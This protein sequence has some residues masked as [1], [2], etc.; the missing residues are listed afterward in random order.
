MNTVRQHPILSKRVWSHEAGLT[1]VQWVGLSA[2]ALVA[3]VVIVGVFASGGSQEI[4]QA[5]SAGTD[6]RIDCLYNNCEPWQNN[7]AGPRAGTAAQSSGGASLKTAGDIAAASSSDGAN[8]KAGSPSAWDRFW[9][10]AGDLLGRG[11]QF[12]KRLVSDLGDLAG[13]AIDGIAGWWNGLP[14]WAKGLIL[15]IGVAIVVVVALV[16]LSVAWPVVVLAGIGAVAGGLIY[17]ISIGEQGQFNPLTGI[18]F[19]L[20]GAAAFGILGHVGV[21]AAAKAGTIAGVKAAMTLFFKTA[22]ATTLKSIVSW[23]ITGDTPTLE[24]VWLD[25]TTSVIAAHL[26]TKLLDRVLAVRAGKAPGLL[27]QGRMHGG[28]IP[29]LVDQL[30]SWLNKAKFGRVSGGVGAFKVIGAALKE[31]VKQLLKA[32]GKGHLPEGEDLAKAGLKVVS[33]PLVPDGVVGPIIQAGAVEAIIEGGQRVLQPQPAPSPT[34]QRP[35]LAPAP[36]PTP[37]PGP[38]PIYAPAT[39]PRSPSTT[40]V[41]VQTPRPN[42]TPAPVGTPR[43]NVTPA[44]T[45][46]ANQTLAPLSTSRPTV[47]PAPT[48][49]PK[50]A[51]TPENNASANQTLAPLSTARPAAAPAPTNMPKPAVTPANTTSA[52]QTLAPAGTTQPIVTPES[53]ASST[54]VPINTPRPSVTPTNNQ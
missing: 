9:K 32:I 40:P 22:G 30:S 49:M 11:V 15:G 12:G 42:Q 45:T 50:H 14:N 25:F 7:S 37:Q 47:A 36:R 41:P 33:A 48:N 52:N 23:L 46:S 38:A 2:V 16:L 54:S 27:K 34:L 6:R 20:L 18:F 39:L 4:Q 31:P 1:S 21:V 24:S 51:V 26:I 44:N 17:G 19:S 5:A 10:G 35:A 3:I 28:G 53:T 8:V 43:P 13:K 29:R